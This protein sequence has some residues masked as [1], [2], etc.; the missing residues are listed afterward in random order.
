MKNV[1][2]FLAIISVTFIILS[3]SDDKSD[4]SESDYIYFFP[5]EL[6]FRS[7]GE[8]KEITIT[9]N[10]DWYIENESSWCSTSVTEGANTQTIFIIVKP[11][12]ENQE[13]KTELRIKTKNNKVASGI[14]SI[15]QEK[16]GVQGKI[17]FTV[18]MSHELE[19]WI[20]FRNMEI[21]GGSF[22]TLSFPAAKEVS[23]DWG[24]G[25][26]DYYYKATKRLTHHYTQAGT[27]PI[28]IEG[29]DIYCCAIVGHSKEREKYNIIKA[30]IKCPTLEA[31]YISSLDTDGLLGK[32]EYVCPMVDFSECPNLKY[33]RLYSPIEKINISNCKELKILD[34]ARSKLSNIDLTNNTKLIYCCL[35][36]TNCR[37]IDV[38]KCTYLEILKCSSCKKLSSMDISKCPALTHID[39]SYCD[40]LSSIDISYNKKLKYIHFSDCNFSTNTLNN[41]FQNLPQGEIWY[42]NNLKR[43]STIWINRNPGSETCNTNIAEKKGW[44]CNNTK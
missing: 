25:T 39:F 7:K 4:N 29:E 12:E 6:I 41:I 24:D 34:A 1:F 18:K 26:K 21:G 20:N 8:I 37:S 32:P 40:N 10:T 5:E 13:R 38:S 3:C 43:Q 33:I 27:Y 15:V 17:S 11:N 31:I 14:L 28:T 42:E 44:V 9:S 30:D 23:I 16:K 35:Y 2:T 22:D 36:E 19:W